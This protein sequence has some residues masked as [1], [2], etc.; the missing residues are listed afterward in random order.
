MFY[1]QASADWWESPS[2]H[3][4][5]QALA[6]QALFCCIRPSTL[7]AAEV[8]PAAEL[9]DA[10]GLLPVSGRK[11]QACIDHSRS[12]HPLGNGQCLDLLVRASH[13]GPHPYLA[14]QMPGPG[15]PPGMLRLLPER[16]ACWPDLWPG[17]RSRA[18]AVVLQKAVCS[19]TSFVREFILHQRGQSHSTCVTRFLQVP[20]STTA[21][22]HACFSC[23][24]QHHVVVS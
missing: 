17:K 5:L 23:P 14:E 20:R 8:G 11:L 6:G 2:D 10:T 15:G 13:R 7:P 1:T 19:M 24:T 4:S 16:C 18:R 9:L 12:N 22:F 3:H 21:V